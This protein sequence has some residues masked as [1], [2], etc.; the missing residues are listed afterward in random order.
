M[1][2]RSIMM[3]AVAAITLMSGAASA[4]PVGVPPGN[5]PDGYYSATDHNGYYDHNGTYRHIQEDRAQLRPTAAPATSS[6][7]IGLL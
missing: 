4:Q 3:S 2:I 7:A 5:D 1:T 6:P